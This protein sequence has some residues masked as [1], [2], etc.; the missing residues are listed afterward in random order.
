MKKLFLSAIME[1][2]VSGALDISFEA[3]KS[4]QKSPCSR[5]TLFIIAHASI[6]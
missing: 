2:F 6:M 1:E 4:M 3:E 5:N